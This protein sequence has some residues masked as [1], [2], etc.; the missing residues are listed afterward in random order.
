MELKS[1]ILLGSGVPGWGWR[2]I[3]LLGTHCFNLLWRGWEQSGACKSGLGMSEQ[4]L[5]QGRAQSGFPVACLPCWKRSAKCYWSSSRGSICWEVAGTS[6]SL[7]WYS[8]LS[9]GIGNREGLAFCRRVNLALKEKIVMCELG[10]ADSLEHS[11][12]TQLSSWADGCVVHGMMSLAAPVLPLRSCGCSLWLQNWKDS[13]CYSQP[14]QPDGVLRCIGFLKC[15][16][17]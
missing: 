7:S 6:P 5:P 16:L 10:G 3:S 11:R 1:H 15:S 4:P 13:L 14:S 9:G 17:M 2:V 8:L 12:T